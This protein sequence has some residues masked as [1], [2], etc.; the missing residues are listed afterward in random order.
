[1][2]ISYSSDGLLSK[3]QIEEL[4]K[5]HGIADTYDFKVI[6]YNTYKSKI[7]LRPK[8]DEYLF[9]IKKGEL[10]G[11]IN[12]I[13][14]NTIIASPMNYIGGKA[15]LLPQILPNFPTKINTFYDVFAGGANVTVN[16]NAENIKINDLNYYVIDILKVFY[17]KDIDILL[18]QIYR[19]IGEYDLSKTNEQG[20]K[21]FRDAYNK[22]QDPVMLYT[23][24]CYS[25]N[26]QFRFNN[27][28]LIQQS[29]WALT[30]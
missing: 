27:N 5:E 12:T 2:F 24:I 22:K 10:M 6:D 29:F 3:Q 21:A 23:L 13:V 17:E 15:K 28:I 30:T 9:Y 20:F 16:I 4:L 25:F 19:L 7:V 18:N 8:V 26:Y 14:N 11:K 1:M